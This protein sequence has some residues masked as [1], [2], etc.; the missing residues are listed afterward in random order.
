MVKADVLWMLTLTYTPF[1]PFPHIGLFNENIESKA[2]SVTS[3][4][5]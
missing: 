1:E 5:L 3:P 2:D 4:R